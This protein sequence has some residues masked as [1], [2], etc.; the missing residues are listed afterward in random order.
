V[1][2]DRPRRLRY[3]ARHTR[4]DCQEGL[5]GPPSSVPSLSRAITIPVMAHPQCPAIEGHG[6][7]A[8]F[9][10]PDP[11]RGKRRSYSSSCPRSLPV[12]RLMRCI[13]A[14]AWQVIA[15]Y[16]LAEVSSS[17]SS[18][19]WTFIRVIGQLN[20][21]RV[22]MPPYQRAKLERHDLAQYPAPRL[23]VIRAPRVADAR[24][25]A[26]AKPVVF[27][28]GPSL[29]QGQLEVARKGSL[30]LRHPQAAPLPGR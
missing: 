13:R 17:L 28:A 26:I 21:R 24:N 16:S 5:R 22:G 3:V 29:W 15:S 27:A 4:G 11:Q 18:Q 19:C 10:P 25:C 12:F 30:G 9:W 7:G 23:C 1:Q 2:P 8:F 14:Q 20:S 6:G